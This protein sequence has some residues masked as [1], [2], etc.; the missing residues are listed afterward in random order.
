MV[1]TRKLSE[2]GSVVTRTINSTKNENAA[3]KL[4]FDVDNI[5][6]Y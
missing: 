1:T 6:I 3:R 4:P 5:P 2:M